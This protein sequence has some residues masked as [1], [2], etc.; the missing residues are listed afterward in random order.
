AL[1]LEHGLQLAGLEHLADDV[2]TA[3]ELALD[4]E[5]RDRR[6]VRERL[7]ALAQVIGLEHVQALIGYAEVI[8]D[9]HHLA[10]KPAH[11]K[12]R[13]SLHEQHDVVA[14]QLV[15]DELLDAHWLI[16]RLILVAG[17]TPRFVNT[18]AGAYPL[19]KT[20]V[21]FSG[22]CARLTVWRSGLQRQC[23]KL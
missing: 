13:R 17:E 16:L 15:V 11:P 20:G 22:T 8:E 10:G 21:H 23:V 9:L 18:C 7:D 5:L 6:P 2:A 1:V 14:L 19:R 12:L 4:V 3:D